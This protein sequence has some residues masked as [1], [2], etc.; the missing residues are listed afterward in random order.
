MDLVA[1]HRASY[2]P[3]PENSALWLRANVCQVTGG[4]DQW[5]YR[6][7]RNRKRAIK[8]E[9]QRERESEE[10]ES[11]WTFFPFFLYLFWLLFNL[12][13]AGFN[14]FHW[15]TKGLS[16]WYDTSIHW[17]PIEHSRALET[18][19][20][21]P[22][23]TSHRGLSTQPQPL[24]CSWVFSELTV[25]IYIY[26]LSLHKKLNLR[27]SSKLKQHKINFFFTWT[28]HQMIMCK[29]SSLCT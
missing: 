10:K 16:Q 6:D 24:H 21:H 29:V 3:D 28:I 4:G 2:C 12:G 1:L 8:N 9:R 14:L 26:T 23:I 20:Q 15:F 11:V 22:E 25:Y 7:M 5:R 18:I 17:F 19:P 13:G 27:Y